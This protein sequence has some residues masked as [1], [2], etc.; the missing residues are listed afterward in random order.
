MKQIVLTANPDFRFS[1][2]AINL[3]LHC[4]RKFYFTYLLHLNQATEVGATFGTV[5]HRVLERLHTWVGRQPIR[6]VYEQ[7]LVQAELEFAN[8]WQ[9]AAKGF[10]FPAVEKAHRV[11]ARRMLE[12]YVRVEFQRLDIPISTQNEIAFEPGF[13]LGSFPVAGRIDR[14]DEFANGSRTIID[15]K[16]GN[17]DDGPNAL[18]KSFLNIA[19]KPNWKASDYQLPLYYFY[20]LEKFGQPPRFLAHY[21]LRNPKGP[22]LTQ[23]EIKPGFPTD[24]ELGKGT[25]KYIYS[26]ELEQVKIQLLGLLEKMNRD[27]NDFPAMPAAYRQCERCPFNFACDGP[28]QGDED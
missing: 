25:R 15:Y 5:L 2:S 26:S 24:E 28:V 23:I 11:R 10:E 9:E 1:A 14:V 27:N 20:W 21:Q 12:R 17:E 13:Q 16:T 7:A 6:P 8:C 18:I 19:H 4:P 3:Y 22:R